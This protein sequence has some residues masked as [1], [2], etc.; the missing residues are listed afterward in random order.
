L[1]LIVTLMVSITSRIVGCVMQRNPVIKAQTALWDSR[2]CELKHLVTVQGY[3]LKD[4]SK[5]WSV[6]IGTLSGML[7][8]REL[9]IHVMRHQYRKGLTK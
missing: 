3:K 4:L 7:N 8:R 9:S 2:M 5:H 6:P 1:T